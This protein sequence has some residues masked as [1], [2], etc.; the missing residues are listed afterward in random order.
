MEL[1][2]AASE[3]FET[4][5]PVGRNDVRFRVLASDGISAWHLLSARARPRITQFVKYSF[6]L[7]PMSVVSPPS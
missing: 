5:L 1:S 4:R 6:R 2:K 7:R 3:H